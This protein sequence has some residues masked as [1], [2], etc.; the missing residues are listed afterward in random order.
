MATTKLVTTR[1]SLHGVAEAVVAGPQYRATGTMRLRQRPGGFG[2]VLAHSGFS[3]VAVAGTDLVL[4]RA[5]GG[6]TRLPLSGTLGDLAGA[7]GLPFGGLED[8]YGGGS[9]PRPDQSIEVD[10]DAAAVL[11]D[12]WARGASAL[13]TFAARFGGAEPA[14]LWPEHF[15]LAISLDSVNYGVSPG[16]EAIAEPYAYVGPPRPQDGE[17]WNQPFGA[18]RPLPDLPDATAV[19]AFFATGRGLVTS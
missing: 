3:V 17:F 5:A 15:D 9:H 4:T 2:T 1:Q 16:D 14:V 11:A 12:A 18:A 8:A 7:A 6:S 13:E 10:P 19:A